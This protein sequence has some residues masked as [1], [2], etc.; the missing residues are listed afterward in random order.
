[1]ME[2]GEI[3]LPVALG[4]AAVVLLYWYFVARKQPSQTKLDEFP[5]EKDEVKQEKRC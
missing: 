3:T 2:A 4:A 5:D 1:M